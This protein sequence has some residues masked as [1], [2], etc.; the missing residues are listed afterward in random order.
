MGTGK[1]ALGR[2]LA[3]LKNMRFL[4]SDDV[5]ARGAGKPIAQI[6]ADEGEAEFRRRER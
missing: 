4:D 3:E 6:F 1:S 5:I 2:K